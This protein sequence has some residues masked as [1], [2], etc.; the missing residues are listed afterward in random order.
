MEEGKAVNK[1]T[2]HFISV[3]RSY[4]TVLVAVCMAFV[5]AMPQYAKAESVEPASADASSGQSN[6]NSTPVNVIILIDIF[7]LV[8][9][10]S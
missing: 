1:K 8:F 4:L 10:I 9:R 3:I 5:I 2:K 6:A 7:L